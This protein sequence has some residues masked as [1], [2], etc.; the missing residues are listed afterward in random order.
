MFLFTCMIYVNPDHKKS[1]SDRCSL[2]VSEYLFFLKLKNTVFLHK[3]MG[4]AYLNL[5]F[6]FHNFCP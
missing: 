5:D 6:K 2:K 3:A 1:L 4:K